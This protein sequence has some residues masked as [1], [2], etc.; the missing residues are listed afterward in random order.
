V[1]A[2]KSSRQNSPVTDP[3]RAF[4]IDA[5]HEALDAERSARGLTWT[6]LAAEIKEPFRGMIETEEYTRD[7]TD[8][9]M[10]MRRADLEQRRATAT[11]AEAE[12]L[13]PGFRR[14]CR[15]RGSGTLRHFNVLCDY[16]GT[17]GPA[18][19]D[20]RLW[21]TRLFE[22]QFADQANDPLLRAEVDIYASLLRR[23]IDVLLATRRSQ[24]LRDDVLGRSLVL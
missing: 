6:E 12:H 1:S 20:L 4:D 7:T 15:D 21:A 10:V 8:M 5:L 22:F 3:L 24:P 16:F 14:K 9:R 18:D 2:T 17:L 19:A 11:L 13:V 23:H